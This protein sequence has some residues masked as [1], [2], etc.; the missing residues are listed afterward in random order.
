[1][2]LLAANLQITLTAGRAGSFG[3]TALLWDRVRNGFREISQL[4]PS[5]RTTSPPLVV[6]QMTAKRLRA[7]ENPKPLYSVRVEMPMIY[8]YLTQTSICTSM[9]FARRFYLSQ[10]RGHQMLRLRFLLGKLYKVYLCSISA[11][12]DL[13]AVACTSLSL[14]IPP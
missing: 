5:P 3:D 12:G 9:H 10:E 11:A 4:P 8:H 2:F 13:I 1:M 7:N 14:Y 6:G